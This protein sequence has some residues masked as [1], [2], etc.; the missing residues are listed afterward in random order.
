MLDGRVDSCRADD[1]RVGFRVDPAECVDAADVNEVI[2]VCE[3]K[4]DHR[5][6]ALPSGEHLGA[7]AELGEQRDRFVDALRSVIVECRG[8]HRRVAFVP[9]TARLPSSEDRS[10]R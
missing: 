4:R 7:V 9:I 2:E 10:R 6:E 8:L 3:P 1:D 5:H